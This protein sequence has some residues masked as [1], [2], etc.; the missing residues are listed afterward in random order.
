MMF[1][2]FI[3]FR[4]LIVMVMVFEPFTTVITLSMSLNSNEILHE[5]LWDGF[6][7]EWKISITFLALPLR[8]KPLI[9][10]NTCTQKCFYNVVQIWHNVMLCKLE[11]HLF[12][13]LDP[14][15]DV[16]FFFLVVYFSTRSSLLSCHSFLT[17][18]HFLQWLASL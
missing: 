4:S 14:I 9:A 10:T 7:Y 18:F 11:D 8:A 6:P 5:V 17:F 15:S 16:I 13:S 3:W 12:C 1:M 2:M